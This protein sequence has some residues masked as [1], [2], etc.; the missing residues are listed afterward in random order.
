MYLTP[1]RKHAPD[2][3]TAPIRSCGIAASR[4]RRA[5]I[6]VIAAISL[7]VTSCSAGHGAAAPSGGHAL[8]GDHAASGSHT[9]RRPAPPLDA[10]IAAGLL[11]APVSRPVV[12]PDG[13]DL[14]IAGGLDSAGQSSA[15]VFRL[16][17]VS[18]AMSQLGSLP[19][20][21]HDAAGAV[22][23]GAD[24]VFGGG[25]VAST[26]SVQ[27][28]QPGSGARLI[29]RLPAPRSDLAAAT[30]GGTTYLVGGYDG[31]RWSPSVLATTGGTRFRVAARLRVPVRYPAVAAIGGQIIVAGGLARTGDVRAI[32]E[33]D[34]ATG[35]VTVIGS[36]PVPLAHAAALVIGGYLYVAGGQT[37]TASS[38]RI[39]AV[40]PATGKVTP[41]GILPMGMSDAGAATVGGAGYL[42]GGTSTS[43]LD[44]VV[45]L[46][47]AS[48]S[49]AQAAAGFPFSGRLLIADRGNDR[50]LLVNTAKKVLWRYPSPAAPP[51][52][53]GFYFP[54]DAFFIHHGTGIITN[55]EDNNDITEI[56]FPSGKVL[57]QYGH[58]GKAGAA[59]GYL[60]QPDDAYLLKNGDITVADAL[61]C[62]VLI[63]TPGKRVTGQIGTN[64]ACVHQPPADLGYP[65]GDTPLPNGNLLISEIDGSWVSEYTRTG[66]LAWSVHLPIAYPSDPQ[67]IGPD[68]YLIADYARPGGLYEFT[69]SGKILWHYAPASGPGMLDHPSLA[70][71]LP[72]GLICVN[73]DYND[74]VVIIN[75]ATARIVWQ[76]GR[77][78]HPGTAPGL[79][80]IPDGFDLLAP[81]NTTPTHPNTG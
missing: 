73:D 7:A 57:W 49:A 30:V 19:Q 75:P 81:N 52:P 41:A 62:R 32:Q 44:S 36:L 48:G 4:G 20:A 53:G 29:G 65:N 56:G 18:G 51:P 34:P 37:R 16:D 80:N 58:P 78:A 27:A 63:I 23:G 38:D 40:D 77:T 22:I 76:Y 3:T 8:P 54:D 47:P 10:S 25:T 28:W 71:R 74:R 39:W 72:S 17:P 66:H 33:I 26:A 5:A 12:L 43:A 64:G 11:P 1:Q 50:L 9:P 14:V 2:V 21:T 70:E 31:T 46:R 79:L 60:H 13:R 61:N 42:V 35:H 67:Q 68:R 6:V 24:V 55:E 59:P 15:G 69:R 45:V